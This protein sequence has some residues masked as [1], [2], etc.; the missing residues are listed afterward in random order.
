MSVEPRMQ[1]QVQGSSRHSKDVEQRVGEESGAVAPKPKPTFEQIRQPKDTGSEDEQAN[2]HSTEFEPRVGT[3]EQSTDVEPQGN[4]PLS[5]TAS[6]SRDKTP[7][8]K[9]SGDGSDVT[10]PP[11]SPK[12][13]TE[14]FVG[15]AKAFDTDDGDFLTDPTRPMTPT[16]LCKSSF[17]LIII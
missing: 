6:H 11:L 10:S 17:A 3:M 4:T 2:R 16:P 14:R 7:Q 9:S 15:K 5:P 12:S 1:T 8:D 13:S